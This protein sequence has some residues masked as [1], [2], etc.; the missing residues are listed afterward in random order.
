MNIFWIIVTSFLSWYVIGCAVLAGIDKDSQLFE[1]AGRA[2]Y[3]L[4]GLV[5]LFW[6]VIL[7]FYFKNR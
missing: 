1:W 5:P 7:F 6:P 4:G 3:R 2:P